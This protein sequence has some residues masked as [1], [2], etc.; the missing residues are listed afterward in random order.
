VR[1]CDIKEKTDTAGRKKVQEGAVRDWEGNW[2]DTNKSRRQGD[3]TNWKEKKLKGE[4]E[5]CREEKEKT[6]SGS[7]YWESGNKNPKE[8]KGQDKTPPEKTGRKRHTSETVAKGKWSSG[9]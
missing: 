8:R 6:L 4:N 2:S 5:L 7:R 1:R 3:W 9:G